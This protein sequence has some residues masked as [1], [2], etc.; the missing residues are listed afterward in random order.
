MLENLISPWNKNKITFGS[1]I[2]IEWQ[3]KDRNVHFDFNLLKRN[4]ADST[5]VPDHHFW[6]GLVLIQG[7]CQVLKVIILLPS[8]NNQLAALANLGSHGC[9]KEVKACGI[10][11]FFT[12]FE[13]IV[14]FFFNLLFGPLCG[15]FWV[16]Q[17]GQYFSPQILCVKRM[18]FSN[19]L[20]TGL[21]FGKRMLDTEKNIIFEKSILLKGFWYFFRD[22]LRIV[23]DLI[24]FLVVL[25]ISVN[26]FLEFL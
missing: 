26:F 20:S 1:E 6:K 15:Q 23:M 2:N 14:E 10:M 21:W 24:Q 19:F 3:E 18:N 4:Q 22:L 25:L 7:L 5:H 17:Q 12:Q 13:Q 8:V 16:L 11:Q 9:L